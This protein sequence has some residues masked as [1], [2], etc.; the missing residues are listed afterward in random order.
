MNRRDSTKESVYKLYS[1]GNWTTAHLNITTKSHRLY[2]LDFL[3]ANDSMPEEVA[4]LGARRYLGVE[5][6]QN[7]GA[8]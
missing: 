7:Q 6:E 4:P 2:F 5:G 8:E 1:L 3:E